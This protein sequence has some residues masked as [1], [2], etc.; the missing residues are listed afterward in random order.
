MRLADPCCPQRAILIKPLLHPSRNSPASML[1]SLSV[2]ITV[3]S[4]VGGNASLEMGAPLG[5]IETQST[6]HLPRFIPEP[7]LLLAWAPLTT[8]S[9]TNTATFNFILT[10]SRRWLGLSRA[11]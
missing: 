7:G 5:D 2:S 6:S 9:E 4:A 8:H 11:R 10:A 3:K 1:P